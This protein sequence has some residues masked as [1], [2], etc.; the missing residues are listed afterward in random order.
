MSCIFI[1][2]FQVEKTTSLSRFLCTHMQ[3]IAMHKTQST[4]TKH[5]PLTMSRGI[6]LFLNQGTFWHISPQERTGVLGV[7]ECPEKKLKIK[8]KIHVGHT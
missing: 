4:A 1:F 3:Q 6:E 5:D 8:K 7:L 2:I